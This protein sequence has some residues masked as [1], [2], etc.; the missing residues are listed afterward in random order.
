MSK[1]SGGNYEFATRSK[2]ESLAIQGKQRIKVNVSK[3]LR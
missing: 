1:F 2:I 3:Y